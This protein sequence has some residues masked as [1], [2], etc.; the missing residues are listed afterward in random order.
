MKEPISV[1]L[2]VD[3]QQIDGW[4]SNQVQMT[5]VRMI[6]GSH[7]ALLKKDQS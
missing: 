1:V 3:S 2:L 7:H 6:V 4:V 5:E